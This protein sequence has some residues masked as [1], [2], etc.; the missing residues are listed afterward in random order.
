[1]RALKALR[2]P[3]GQEHAVLCLLEIRYIINR[4]QLLLLHSKSET[5][6][7]AYL[8][9]YRAVVDL[10]AEASASS[11]DGGPARPTPFYTNESAVELGFGTLLYFVVS[12]C[13]FLGVRVA[14][15]KLMGQ[16]ARPRYNV[17]AKPITPAVAR[18]II[19]IEHQIS[20]ADLDTG[21]WVDDGELPPEERRVVSV[22]FHWANDVNCSGPL[23]QVSFLSRDAGS[24]KIIAS[25]EWLN[26]GDC[27]EMSP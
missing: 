27:P 21:D 26:L 13:R 25:D 11:G 24:G 18:R 8:A 7:D 12:K 3:G 4:T 19:E 6:Y 17:W 22:D 10:A 2:R 15:L 14:A 9:S 1:M 5:D 16:L 20:L 23:R